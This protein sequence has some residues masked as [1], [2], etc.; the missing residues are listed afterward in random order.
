MRESR[1][2]GLVAVAGI[3]LAAVLVV[4][5]HLDADRDLN[6][7]TLTLSDFA[8]SDRGGVIDVAMVLTAAATV[9]ALVGLR[10]AGVRIGTLATALLAVWTGGLLVAAVVPTDAPGLPLTG[11]GYVHR[12]VSVAAS[13]RFTGRGRRRRA[14]PSGNR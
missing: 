12:Y 6:P 1:T 10:R 4:V 11:G 7:W 2:Y 5:G 14:H 9:T 3:V 8:V 13:L